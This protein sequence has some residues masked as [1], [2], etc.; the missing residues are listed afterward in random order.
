MAMRD[1]CIQLEIY[2]N[3]ILKPFSVSVMT[4]QPITNHLLKIDLEDIWISQKH[5]GL[6]LMS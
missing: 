4:N 1:I 3:R 6:S 5:V 2:M